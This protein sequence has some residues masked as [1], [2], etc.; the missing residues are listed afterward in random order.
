MS[1]QYWLFKSEPDVFSI[2]DLAAR[3]GQKEPWDGVRNYQARNF[4][5]DQMKKGDLVLFYHSNCETPGVVGVA[6]ITGEARPDP[7]S[8]NPDSPYHDPKVKQG[9]ARWLMVEVRFKEKFVRTVSLSTLKSDPKLQDMLVV[10]RGNRL[11]IT[12]VTE[13]EFQHIRQLG[14]S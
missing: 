6:E 3:P 7:G 8:W 2:D 9:E 5:R 14:Q 13:K 4:M 12:P 10:R 11:S 1:R